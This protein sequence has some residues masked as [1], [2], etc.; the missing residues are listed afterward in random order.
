MDYVYL[1]DLNSYLNNEE[2]KPTDTFACA[3]S[4]KNIFAFS[5]ECYVYLVPLEKPNE[6]VPVTLSNSSCIFISWSDDSQ[7]LLNVFKNGMCHIYSV[8]VFYL[9][10]N[11]IIYR[12]LARFRVK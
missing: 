4:S 7:Y 11:L 6:L 12:I 3:L 2:L 1:V 9:D 8:K 5:S 10:I